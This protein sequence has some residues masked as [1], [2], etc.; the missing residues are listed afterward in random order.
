MNTRKLSSVLFA[1]LL[2]AT[3]AWSLPQAAVFAGSNYL[4]FTPSGSPWSALG[5]WR[6]EFRMHGFGSRAS[7]QGI[8]GNN[9]GDAQ[10][11]IPA[12]QLALR[13]RT[14]QGTSTEMV[15]SLAGR[16]DVRVRFQRVE[17]LGKMYLEMW[18]AD[19]TGYVVTQLN[20]T[21]GPYDARRQ[22]YIGS[23]WGAASELYGSISFMRWFSATLPLN[24]PVAPDSITTPADLFDLELDGNTS[25]SSPANRSV[26]V[27]GGAPAYSNTTLFSPVANLSSQTVRAGSILQLDASSS[28]NLT[29]DQPL[30]YFWTC[31]NA[32]SP[33]EF[34]SRIG[35]Q[36]Q[37]RTL[38]GGTYTV[39]LR[40]TNSEQLSHTIDVDMGAVPTDA[41]GVVILPS[42]KL[43]LTIGP[44]LRS[45]ASQWAWFDATEKQVADAIGS[46]ITASPGDTP[47]AGTVTLS[48]GSTTVTG[49]GTT[50]QS[51]FSC[52]GSDLIMLHYPL[53]GG[54][55]GRRVYTVNSCSSQ[56]SMTMSP[57]YDASAGTATGVSYGKTTNAE[58]A[59]WIN[60]SNNWNYYDA[61]TAFYRLYYRT[62][63]ERYRTHARSLAD[64]WYKWPFDGGRAWING[65]GFWMQQP[66]MMALLGLM[67][68]AEDGKPEYWPGIVGS[69]DFVYTQ[70]NE[71]WFPS[72]T[73]GTVGEVREQG[74][75]SLFQTGIAAM[76]PDATARGLALGRATAAFNSY[77]KL[78]QLPDG[79]WRFPIGANLYYSG[80]G[81]I[82]WQTGFTASYLTLLHRLSNNSQVLDSLQ[83]F[84]NFMSSYGVDP[85]NDGGYYDTFYTRCPAYD[86]ES[87]G[88][89]SVV[90][91]S[92][93]ILGSGTNFLSRYS[94]N[95]TDRIAI[96]MNSGNRVSYTVQACSSN[97]SMT[98][99]QAHTDVTESG[100][101]HL[102]FPP[103][104]PTHGCGIC[105]WGTCG[106]AGTAP[107]SITAARTLLNASHSFWGYL[108]AMG[109]GQ[110]YKTTGDRL[111][112]QNLGFNGPGNDGNRGNYNDVVSGGT[113]PGYLANVFYSKE[114]A[115]VGGASGAQP[116]LAWR[117]G[118]PQA[119]QLIPL[120]A[121]F[122]LSAVPNAT[123]ARVTLTR[124]NGEI[125]VAV[126]TASPCV[127]NGDR[128]Q[129]DHQ[130]V[131][132]YLDA[133]NKVVARGE[134]MRI[135]V[136]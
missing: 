18:N 92:K 123:K 36:A 105:S 87:Q 45:G 38:L 62:G 20:Y 98:I 135:M 96:D 72:A 27:N 83:S 44:L 134:R 24:A 104:G 94:C 108:Y 39:R 29:N 35:S 81:T 40:V 97:T 46:S 91:G 25:D 15:L 58:T 64:K 112:A 1:V 60:G 4:R 55:T 33:C 8:F 126:C 61:V 131:V 3:A 56:Q 49:T 113:P 14:Y 6:I 69:G 67:L 101:R 22:N 136:P 114:F 125:S 100:R 130:F 115:F 48:N 31:A 42:A 85:L 118:V 66:R 90:N 2:T 68:R 65:Q 93:T 37:L 122:D 13:C 116:Y 9:D 51:T 120:R 129:G 77:W 74:Y 124:P 107:A 12:G 106:S 28:S 80:A 128:R 73:S 109:K 103:S 21:P 47:L 111:F 50:F 78:A 132:D 17:S 79:S 133:N 99:V 57:A 7:T 70:W 53:A 41:N 16:T 86:K 102:L 121:G 19:G 10:C 43:E 63:M 84:A 117:L 54:G 95:Q 5:S 30:Q 127:V 76:H 110:G 34:V 32:P 88:T 26:N 59:Q 75:V 119:Q 71:N 11:Q 52:N 82:P 89:V 23:L